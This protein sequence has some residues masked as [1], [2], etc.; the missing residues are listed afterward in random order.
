MSAAKADPKSQMYLDELEIGVTGFMIVMVCRIWDVNA[1]TGRYLS[2][3]FVIGEQFR[4]CFAVL[5]EITRIKDGQWLKSILDFDNGLQM[6]RLEM[7]EIRN[8][9]FKMIGGLNFREFVLFVSSTRN[10]SH[11]T[12]IGGENSRRKPRFWV[13]AAFGRGARFPAQTQRTHEMPRGSTDPDDDIPCFLPNVDILAACLDVRV[14]HVLAVSDNA[15]VKAHEMSPASACF[16]LTAAKE[17]VGNSDDHLELPVSISSVKYF[18]VLTAINTDMVLTVVMLVTM[19]VS[20]RNTLSGSS[21]GSPLVL[22]EETVDRN[23]A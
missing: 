8:I 1:T 10:K 18:P 23:N 7:L 21:N 13:S 20:T 4:Y 16:Q 6:A 9:L 19:V 15:N 5:V 12:N 3:A 11:L 22:D 17:G 2:T 14:K